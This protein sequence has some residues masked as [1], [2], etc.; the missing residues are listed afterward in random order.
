LVPGLMILATGFLLSCNTPA[1]EADLHCRQL[2]DTVGFASSPAKMDSVM[3]RIESAFGEKIRQK[4]DADHLTDSTV[5]KA[6]ICPH[7]DYAY[8]HY[9]YPLGLRHMKAGTVIMFGVAHKARSFNL[10]DR[11]V[12][13]SFRCWNSAYGPVKVSDL[14]E[15]LKVRLSPDHFVV[16]DSM[17]MVEHSLEAMVPFLEYYDPSV[18][19]VPVLVPA[20]SFERSRAIAADFAHALNDIARERNLQWG[21]DFA[22]LISS[23]A[24]HYGDRDWGGANYA[25]YGADS[26][27]YTRAVAHEYEIIGSCLK[28]PVTEEK[29][30]R[31][32]EYTLDPDD[33]R[34]YR[35]TWCGR[36]SIPMGL[37]VGLDLSRLQGTGFDGKLLGYSTSIAEQNPDFSDI[38]MGVT[39]VANIRH[40]VGYAAIGY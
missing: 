39:A 9:L 3:A 31:F 22:I 13:D 8:A 1:G 33:Y 5:W 40:W 7:D 15:E 34:Q 21:K 29:I 20:V 28:G 23:D 35:W 18:E 14:R 26:T 25:L 4:S 38:G 10:E 12:F 24:V 16:H 37:M 30:E 11:L 19:I 2:A 32:T 36:Y 6:L 27:G 17:Q